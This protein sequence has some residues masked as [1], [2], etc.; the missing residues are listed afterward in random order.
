MDICD[1]SNRVTGQQ[2]G[3]RMD[4]CRAC[5]QFDADYTECR[6]NGAAVN[7]TTWLKAAS[8]PL[9]KWGPSEAL[10]FL[11]VDGMMAP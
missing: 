3:A 5:P 11:D 1:D 6:E 7:T 9:G 2:A 8:C 10:G 4:V